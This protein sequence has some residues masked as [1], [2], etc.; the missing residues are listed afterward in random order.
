MEK[1]SVLIS[2]KYVNKKLK[3]KP[4]SIEFL[5]FFPHTR[6]LFKSNINL[7][8]KIKKFTVIL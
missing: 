6:S 4:N 1:A 2:D 3:K 7:C 5:V 8:I